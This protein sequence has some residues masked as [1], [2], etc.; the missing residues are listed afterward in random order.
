MM[1]AGGTVGAQAVVIFSDDFQR[2]A[3]DSLGTTPVGGFPWNE[4]ESS[5]SGIRLHAAK[6]LRAGGKAGERFLAS[7]NL[8][9]AAGYS[10]VLENN[11]GPVTWTFNL[12]GGIYHDGFDDGERGI[13]FLLAGS[14]ASTTEGYG[15]AVAYGSPAVGGKIELRLV[16]YSGGLDAD[17]NLTTL[18]STGHQYPSN[19]GHK[20]GVS[21]TF[22]PGAD[23]WSLYVARAGWDDVWPAPD[24]GSLVGAITDASFTGNSLPHT[25][26]FFNSEYVSTYGYADNFA[27]RV[28]CAVPETAS[29]G[30]AAGLAL[31]GWCGWRRFRPRP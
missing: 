31:F 25:G 15:Y 19:A 21:V 28:D 22:E 18:I 2:A 17:A 20:F 3:S 30:V 11:L 9:S 26:L 10:S 6:E 16:R 29:A 12:S 1:L 5:A 24:S 4:I 27:L 14:Q 23:A 13:A 7:V 8:A